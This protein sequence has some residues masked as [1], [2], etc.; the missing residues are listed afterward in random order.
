[1]FNKNR[2]ELLLI[3]KSV[4]PIIAYVLAFGISLY[5]K[6]QIRIHDFALV[7]PV[8]QK[9]H[10]RTR[11][12]IENPLLESLIEKHSILIIKVKST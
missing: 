1:M 9:V 2:N 11:S 6:L 8:I 10:K 4:E 12:L 3:Q 5:E 7:N